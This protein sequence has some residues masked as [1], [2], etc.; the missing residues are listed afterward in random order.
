[1]PE[2][3]RKIAPV[4]TIVNTLALLAFAYLHFSAKNRLAYIDSNKLI[5]GYHGMAIAR[6]EYQSKVA[7]WKANIDTLVKEVKMEIATYEKENARMTA[8]EREMSKKLIQTK[9]QQ[10]A[11]YQK[12]ASEKAGQAD[13]EATKKVVDEINAYIKDY[14]QKNN[15]TII[16]AATEYGNIA[17]AKDH[18]DL[19]EEILSRLNERFPAAKA[20]K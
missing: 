19:T 8:R 15:Y 12:A 5:N 4:L 14:G 3:A 7:V 18:L 6:G 17:F 20:V 13:A 10:L 11:D 1:M 9:Q 2:F 16:L